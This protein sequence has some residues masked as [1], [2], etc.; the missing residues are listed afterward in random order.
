MHVIVSIVTLR[1]GAWIFYFLKKKMF[2]FSQKADIEEAEQSRVARW[3]LFKPKI[4]MWVNFGG[5]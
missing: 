2:H 4:P 5:P 3:Y 1:T